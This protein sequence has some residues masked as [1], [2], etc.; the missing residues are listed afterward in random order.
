MFNDPFYFSL[1]RKY[2]SLFGTLFNNIRITRTDESGVKKA[3]IKVPITY[4]PKDKMMARL[5][6]NPDSDLSKPSA[7]PTMPYI[8]FIQDTLDYDGS[9]KLGTS[10]RSSFR[11]TASNN[12]LRTQ[13]NPVPY[14]IGYTLFII[15]K[16]IEDG[17]KILEQILPYFTPSWTVT[18]EL[19]PE[20]DEKRDLEFV[21]NS[22]TSEDTYDGSFKERR[23]II[24]TLR[25][26]LKAWFFGPVTESKI[27]KFVNAQFYIANTDDID[28]SIGVTDVTERVTVQ[29]GVTANGLPT[30]NLQ[31]TIP[32]ANVSITDDYGYVT[33][34]TSHDEMQNE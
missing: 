1:L 25:F 29:P 8:S 5:E 34:I 10:G 2:T 12:N 27:I 26:T 31:L 28:D 11:N 33:V 32:Y 18:A 17:N 16:N 21:L 6:A 4:A 24:W 20:M 30:S 14:N 19:I 15:T 3:V 13:Y 9:R 23:S 7:T 22:V